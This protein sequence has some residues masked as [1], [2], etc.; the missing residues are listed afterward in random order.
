MFRVAILADIHGNVPALEAVVADIERRSPDEV[1]VGGDLVGRGPQ[2]SAIVASIRELGW[3]SIRGNHEDYLLEFRRGEVPDEWLESDEWLGPRWMAAELEAADLET[4]AEYPM[5][6]RSE[7]LPQLRLVHGSPFSNNE[8][9]GPWTSEDQFAKYLAA[10]EE[11]VLVACHTHRPLRRTFGEREVVNVG[12]VGLPFNGDPRAQYVLF[13]G[14]ANAVD[15]SFVQVE[16]DRERI[17]EIYDETGFA[18]ATGATSHLL[19]LEIET[20]TP[21]LVPFQHWATKTGRQAVEDQIGA[22]LDF[23]EPGESMGSFFARLRALGT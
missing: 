14:D 19:R 1:L 21:H 20:A 6:L 7:C 18:T 15:V 23:H 5:S 17:L 4:I 22:F 10:V 8:G 12:S 3:P 13:E 2:G 9:I 16:Y 11:P